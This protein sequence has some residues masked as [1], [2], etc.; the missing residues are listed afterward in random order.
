M[1]R[2]IRGILREI[3]EDCIIVESSGIGYGIMVS[4]SV[5]T[6]LPSIGEEVRVY[7][8]LS[9]RED[10][11]Q[12]YGFLYKEDRNMFVQL[13][14]VNGIGPKG[15]LGILSVLKP[16]D[17]R[18]AII[19]GDAKAIAKAPGIGAKT[20]QR[21]ILD[22]KDK[23]NAEEVFTK[24]LDQDTSNEIQTVSVKGAQKEAVQA[25]VAL[26]YSNLEASRAVK[27]VEATPEMSADEILKRSL[28]HLAFL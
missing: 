15:A 9:V 3:E 18:L 14:S 10:A 4:G 19:S 22:L 26:G 12:L 1:I 23:L 25:L 27:K 21:V 11:M 5:L 7:T 13:L 8:Y 28:K 24:L 16:D 2:F 6:L 17:L 20:A